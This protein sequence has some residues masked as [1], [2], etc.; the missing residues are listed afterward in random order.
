MASGTADLEERKESI[1]GREIFWRSRGS[2]PIVYV[3]GV[4]THS[5]DWLPFLERTGGAALD[6][7]G[8][9]RS[10]KDPA[11]DYSMWQL[12]EAFGAFVD[13]LGHDKIRLVV[14][15][16]GM[17]AFLWAL[18]NPERIA[19]LV[20]INSAPVVPGYRWH[21]LARLWRRRGIGELFMATSTRSGLKLLSRQATPRKGPMSDEFVDAAWR[22]FDRPTRRAILQ[23]Y[24]SADESEFAAAGQSLPN[25][26]APTLVI[27]GQK[28]PYLAPWV[29]AALAQRMPNAQLVEVPNAG[30]WPWIDDPTVIA[31]ATEFLEAD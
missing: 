29:G 5:D 4:P 10:G 13:H 14:H 9:G 22:Y 12:A 26:A 17:V 18:Q 23:L 1:G 21:W 30:H 31:T 6:L 25:L 8:F 19:R 3:H 27:W 15:D 20:V 24:R 28:D 16:W 11:D 7:P 2:A